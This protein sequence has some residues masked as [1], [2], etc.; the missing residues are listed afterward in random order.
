MPR[1]HYP[2]LGVRTGGR[3]SISEILVIALWLTVL[4]A[5]HRDYANRVRRPPRMTLIFC[6][7]TSLFLMLQLAH[8]PMLR[9]FQ[10]DALRIEQGQWWR[11]VTAL[12]FQ[13]RWLAGGL[14]NIAALLLV[15]TRAEELLR[16]GEWVAIY[17][18]GALI[19]EGVALRWQPLGAGNSVA[20]CSLAGSLIVARAPGEPSLPSKLLRIVAGAAASV[21]VS[22]RDIHGIAALSGAALCAGSLALRRE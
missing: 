15:G 20:V 7:L 13:D 10:R 16:P 21:L 22:M 3:V 19:A 18:I 8:P 9:T 14:T 6:A 17:W 4:A 5:G 12:F 11:L 2:L 1:P